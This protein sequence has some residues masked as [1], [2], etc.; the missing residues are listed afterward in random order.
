MSRKVKRQK[1]QSD[2]AAYIIIAYDVVDALNSFGYWHLRL[3]IISLLFHM[4]NWLDST[5]FLSVLIQQCATT[6]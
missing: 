3:C 5:V 2:T 4:A 1:Y 6:A